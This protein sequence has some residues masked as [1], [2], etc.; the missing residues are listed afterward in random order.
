MLSQFVFVLK[1]KTSKSLGT[2]EIS[3]LIELALRS[4]V[5]VQHV[6]C[7]YQNTAF[8]ELKQPAGK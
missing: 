2:H 3:V 7:S 8:F 6:S 4:Y 5:L 1:V